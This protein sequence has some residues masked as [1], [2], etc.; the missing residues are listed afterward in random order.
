MTHS[1]DEN[2]WEQ[3]WHAD[4]AGDPPAMAAMP[5][6]PHLVREVKGMVPGTA[7]DVGC[8]SGAEAVWLASQGWQVS[9]ADIAEEALLRAAERA[10]VAGL[11][12]RIRWIKA[13][14]TSWEP[15]TTYDLVTTHYA[16]SAMPQVEF[17]DRIASWVAPGGTLLIVGHLRHDHAHGH[18]RGHGHGDG[19]PDAASVT[20]AE[21][22]AR[23][24]AAAWDI[25]TAEE[26]ERV[27]SHPSRG[28]VVLHDVVVRATRRH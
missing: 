21:I 24:G 3:Q 7:L 4:R 15:G 25:V 1:F 10:A 19:P 27:V 2:Y 16:H 14:L 20:L 23:L 8:G 6:N 12:N 28:P 9:G 22:T 13:D 5:A 11:A 18:G 26:S 17:Y